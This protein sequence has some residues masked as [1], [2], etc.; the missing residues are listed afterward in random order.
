M[1]RNQRRRVLI[2]DPERD[3]AE[4]FARALETHVHECK[5]YWV[6]TPGEARSL[7]I[8]IPFDFVLA[9]FS[10]LQQEHFLLIDQIRKTSS[11]TVILVDA[12]LNQ[13]EYLEK[14]IK[15]GA[16]G[17]FIKPIMINSLRKLIDDFALSLIV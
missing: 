14:V 9:D 2:L 12:Y 4:L 15:M 16:A 10:L 1:T 8:E 5:C 7:F 11:K 17:Y 6:Q 3:T 13:K